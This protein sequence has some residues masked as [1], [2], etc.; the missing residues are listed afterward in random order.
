MPEQAINKFI[1]LGYKITQKQAMDTSN[2]CNTCDKNKT[3]KV[4]MPCG[5]YNN[6]CECIGLMELTCLICNKMESLN[7]WVA[8]VFNREEPSYLEYAKTHGVSPLDV[9]VHSLSTN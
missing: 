5:H 1:R 6:A 2:L 7:G 8:D 3:R 9:S 4:E